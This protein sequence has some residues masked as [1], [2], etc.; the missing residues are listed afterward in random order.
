M[1]PVLSRVTEIIC[2]T[3]R[4][5]SCAARSRASALDQLGLVDRNKPRFG[6]LLVLLAILDHGVEAL[7]DLATT[8][9]PSAR[10]G[11]H[12]RRPARSS[13]RRCG[14]RRGNAGDRT[15]SPA[16]RWRRGPAASGVP[17]SAMPFQR[18]VGGATSARRR[19]RRLIDHRARHR[20]DVV[21]LR[22]LH[23]VGRGAIVGRPFASGALSEDAAQAQED[24]D[25]QR[26]EDDGVNIHVVFA[27]WF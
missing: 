25:R 2:D 4:T 27:F 17:G 21:V 6:F 26:Q 24:E 3:K 11:R 22:T 5:V 7:I 20:N 1:V 13:H 10:G 12:W 8:A 18:S 19:Q 9:D 14:R 23:D 16:R 15:R